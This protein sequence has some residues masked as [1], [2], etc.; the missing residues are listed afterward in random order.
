MTESDLVWLSDV[1]PK[2]KSW[3]AHRAYS[4][5]VSYLY[6][7][8][9]FERYAERI[10]ACSPRLEFA[11]TPDDAGLVEFKLQSTRFCRVRTCPVCQWRRSL[12]WR[13]R[14]CKRFPRVVQDY[15]T[16]RWLFLTLTVRNC[17]VTELRSTLNH[18]TQAWRRL[19]QRKQFPAE[20]FIKS[21]EV[22]RSK[23]GTAHPHIHAIL[24]VPGS[25]F[26]S[27]A[28]LSQR[29]WTRLWQEC[30][31]IDYVP[32]VNIKAVKGKRNRLEPSRVDL[33]ADLMAAVIETLKYSIK[34]ADLVADPRWLEELTHQIHKLRFTAIGGVLRKYF[35]EQEEQEDLIHADETGTGET[36]EEDP[37]F[38]FD[39]RSEVKKYR[40]RK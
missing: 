33:G 3:D 23:D 35:S 16:S 7:L 13:A 10:G 14:F 40:A 27:K 30:L 24:M 25:Y 36:R 15:P 34:E 4:D 26:N 9:E 39:W 19:I 12:M 18:M 5:M 2:D 6:S 8:T 20:G 37:R 22:T 32:V 21:T 1:S 29:E 28:Y 38:W 31:Q 11:L 17:D